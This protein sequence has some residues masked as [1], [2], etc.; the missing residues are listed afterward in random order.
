MDK[1]TVTENNQPFKE[2]IAK[3]DKA[4]KG[5][6]PTRAFDEIYKGKSYVV[7]ERTDSYKLRH[8]PTSL[9]KEKTRQFHAGDRV[10]N[11]DGKVL[12]VLVQINQLVVVKEEVNNYNANDLTIIEHNADTYKV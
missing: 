1:K 11:Q 9:P 2:E 4:E 5:S 6:G 7:K 10:R 8:F 3:K 12:T